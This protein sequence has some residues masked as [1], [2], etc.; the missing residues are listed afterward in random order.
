LLT[1]ERLVGGFVDFT[2]DFVFD[3]LESI[4]ID[5]TFVDQE[6]A[7]TFHRVAFGIARPFFVGP[8]EF[9]VI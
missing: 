3:L 6:G 7:K 5:H 2:I 4:L 1:G 8:V 9:F